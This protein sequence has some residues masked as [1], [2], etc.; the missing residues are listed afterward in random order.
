MSAPTIGPF[1]VVPYGNYHAFEIQAQGRRIAVVVAQPGAEDDDAAT[2]ETLATATLFAAAPELLDVLTAAW[3]ALRS[4]QYGN[5]SPDL[6]ADVADRA[7][8]AIAKAEGR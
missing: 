3:H 8:A 2:A 7:E 4:Y 6:A 1:S 5:A